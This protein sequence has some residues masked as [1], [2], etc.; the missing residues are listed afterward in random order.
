MELIPPEPRHGDATRMTDVPSRSVALIVTS[1]PYGVGKDYEEGLGWDDLMKL[2][3]FTLHEAY[4]VLEEGGR[5]AINTS[6]VG[7]S[8]FMPLPAAVQM[9]LHE[10]GFSLRGEIVWLKTNH[11][12]D[13]CAWGSWRSPHNPVMRSNQERIAIASKGSMARVPGQRE[14]AELGMPHEADITADEFVAA[15]RE[16]WPM[17]PDF[18]TS[19][20]HPAPFP[21]ELP[22]RLIK[23]FTYRG[24][25][26]LDPFMGS[27]TTL[28]AA[29]ETGRRGIG[30]DITP[31]YVELAKRRIARHTLQTSLL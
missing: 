5:I 27:G 19:V 6:G 8:P 16:V 7:R 22:R 25:V 24:D 20:G 14:R 12:S 28:L 21:I 30:Y 23:L 15:T 9:L 11:V 1:P 29:W 18:A 17:R 31:E 10:H 13:G 26:V 3:D 2:L 4:R